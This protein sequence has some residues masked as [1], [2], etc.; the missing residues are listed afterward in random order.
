MKI[1]IDIDCTPDEARGFFGLPDVKP[2]QKKMLDELEQR[3]TANLKAM[4]PEALMK[5]WLPM[6]LQGFEEMQK[7]F[8]GQMG[9]TPS[10]DDKKG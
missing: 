2:L 4:D 3:M 5:T 6:G 10:G 7:T 8:W 9:G 1:R